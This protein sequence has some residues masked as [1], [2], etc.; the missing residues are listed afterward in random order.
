MHGSYSTK[1]MVAG[2]VYN[3]S[4]GINHFR[5]FGRDG[6]EADEVFSSGLPV[7]EID[8]GASQDPIFSLC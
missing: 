8:D 1:G 7:D 6:D 2:K 4:L 5:S 3:I